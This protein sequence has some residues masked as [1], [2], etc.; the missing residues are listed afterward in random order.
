MLHARLPITIQQP[1]DELP[2]AW[3]FKDEYSLFPF[4]SNYE[5]TAKLISCLSSFMALSLCPKSYRKTA[6]IDAIAI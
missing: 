4:L 1:S 2:S 6:A 3:R 5:Y